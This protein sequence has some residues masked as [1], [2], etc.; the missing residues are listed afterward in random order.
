MT[1][2]LLAYHLKS[3][4]VPLVV[5][6]PQFENHW[7]TQKSL[8]D[9]KIFG[10]TFRIGDTHNGGNCPPSYVPGR[11]CGPWAKCDP[12]EHLIWPASEFSLPV[13]KHHIAFK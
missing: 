3:P 9:R 12:R 1:G 5:R 2:K 13:L 6:V 10:A 7:L 4:R 8:I 11:T